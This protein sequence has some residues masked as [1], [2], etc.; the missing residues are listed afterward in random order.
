MSM[1]DPR[2]VCVRFVVDRLA[3]GQVSI[4]VL[5]FPPVSI[6]PPMLRIYLHPRVALTRR[7][8]GRSVGTFQKVMPDRI[9]EEVG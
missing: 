8:D 5:R 3:L 4:R 1:I 2:P 6:I 7:A 9:R